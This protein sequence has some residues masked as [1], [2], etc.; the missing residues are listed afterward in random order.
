M[1]T[2]AAARGK[3]KKKAKAKRAAEKVV[4]K[5]REEAGGQLAFLAPVKIP[6]LKPGTPRHVA[7]DREIRARAGRIGQDFMVVL[8]LC[9]ELVNRKHYERLGF[10]N[11]HDYFE[12]KVP[13]LSWPTMRRY[14]AILTA[15]RRLPAGQRE[16]AMAAMQGIG[17]T[18]AGIIAPVVGLP[19]EG[20]TKWIERAKSLGEDDLR[21]AVRE[22]LDRQLRLQGTEGDGGSPAAKPADQ[23]WLDHTCHIIESFAPDAAAEVREVFEAGKSKL[24]AKSYLS[25]LLQMVKEC[26]T[27]WRIAGYKAEKEK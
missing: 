24:E 26:A 25:V 15:V 10:E 6:G 1:A 3:A 11:P 7:C 14:L 17:V 21:I 20:W 27:E 2:K 13:H 5:P 16:E 22:A 8:R 9:D 12:K 18:K 4:K 23:K 19:G